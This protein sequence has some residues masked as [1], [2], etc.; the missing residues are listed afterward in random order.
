MIRRL[1]AIAA[2]GVLVLGT[3]SARA[4]DQEKF[5]GVWKPAKGV[6]GGMEMPADELAKMS[7]EF[8]G[9]KAKPRHGDRAEEE[10]E[11]TLDASKNPR[12]LD[13]KN[14]DG[15]TVL[16]I[17]EFDG[18]TLKVC[19]SK[20]G[21]ERPAKFESPDGSMVMYIVLKKQAK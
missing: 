1:T 21:G 8:K 15:K 12:T 19:F 4:D 14:A 9:N 18:D 2:V 7:I 20:D 10:A 5:Q 3:G 6:R 11:F 16:G 13:I 17:Y